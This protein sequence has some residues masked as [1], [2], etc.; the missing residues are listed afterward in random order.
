MTDLVEFLVNIE[1][2]TG[3]L[4]AAAVDQLRAAEARRAREL[5]A[6]GSVVA[7]WRIEGRWANAGIWRAPGEEALQRILDSLP[8]RPYMRI[9][10]T[11]L[12]EHPSDPRLASYD[13]LARNPRGRIALAPMPPLSTRVRATRARRGGIELPEFPE[14][15]IRRRS[16]W[17][18]DS[19]AAAA[20][21]RHADTVDRISARIEVDVTLAADSA[22]AVSAIAQRIEA[23]ARAL[24]KARIE[25][26]GLAGGAGQAPPV[27]V[28]PA[29][30]AIVIGLWHSRSLDGVEIRHEH[31]DHD[32]D[33]HISPL[34]PRVVARAFDG[35]EDVLQIRR[36]VT[37]DATAR[38][39][40]LSGD[41][42]T[43]FLRDM[44]SRIDRWVAS[45]RPSSAPA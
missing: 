12:T 9:E 39:A 24:P 14:M 2:D 10:W 23:A 16:D 7:L 8:L 6:D 19:P 20:S 4:D 27:T 41:Q 40:G 36:L 1:I 44:R 28:A 31:A 26:S 38:T 45:S 25:Y 5:A 18:P 32:L 30:A 15:L 22:D 3:D 11:Q 35:G 37:I 21:R 34:T 33:I 13:A 29:D 43:S 17:Q 42:I